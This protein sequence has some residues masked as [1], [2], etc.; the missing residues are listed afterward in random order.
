ME[1][2]NIKDYTQNE[3]KEII[4]DLDEPGYRAGQIFGWLY[5]DADDFEAMTNLSKELR[6]KLNERFY[7][8]KSNIIDEKNL[9]DST[10]FLITL[11]DNNLIET[12]LLRYKYGYTLC[13]SSQVGCKMGCGFCASTINGFVRDLKPG[14]MVEQI[15][16]VERHKNIRVSRVVIMGSGEPLDNYDNVMRFIRIINDKNGINIGARHITISTCGIVPG[17]YKLA[18]EKLQLTL[19]VSLHAAMDEKRLAIMPVNRAYPIK[20]IISAVK[21]YTERTNRRATFEYSMIRGFNDTD[22]D[23]EKLAL[24]IRGILCNVNLIPINSVEETGFLP[25]V[26]ERVM[27]F[28]DKLE[29]FGINVTIRRSLGEEIDAA[30][31]QLRRSYL[32]KQE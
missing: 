26:S 28:K 18:D 22:E 23:A 12:V 4:A 1:K 25:S 27:K 31:G 8:F 17:I 24:L 10:K 19:A 6:T 20:D 14:E 15:M 3:L 7:I 2:K 11:E 5:K 29:E 13:V 16:L 21:Y 32:E 9:T 30:C